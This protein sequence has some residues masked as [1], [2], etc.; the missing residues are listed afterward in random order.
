MQEDIAKIAASDIFHEMIE[1]KMTMM[2]SS[3]SVQKSYLNY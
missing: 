3:K 2:E 1:L